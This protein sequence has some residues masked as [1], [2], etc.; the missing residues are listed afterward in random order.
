MER[1]PSWEANN[2]SASQE[3]LHI[4]RTLVVHSHM[5]KILPLLRIL[6]H[7]NIAHALFTL[8]KDLF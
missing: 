6:M 2:F 1:G 4:L 5:P 8:R 7:I 3:I